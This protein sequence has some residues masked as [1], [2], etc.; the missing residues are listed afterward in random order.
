MVRTVILSF[1][2]ALISSTLLAADE[3]QPEFKKIEAARGALVLEVPAAWPQQR[4]AS[5]IIEHEFSAP[6]AEGDKTPGRLTMMSAGGSVKDN[7]DRWRGQFV[8]NDAEPIVKQKQVDGMKV[9]LVDLQGTYNDRRGPFAPG[10]RRENYRMFGA[11]VDR[12]GSLYFLKF[13]G[14][15]KTM[16]AHEE[17]FQ[18]IIDSIDAQ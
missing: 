16:K 12:E 14:P 8:S 9:H 6:A 3:G 17:A 4:Q 10:V 18:K 5:R 2:L 1:S 11:I 15:K 7:I 13:Y